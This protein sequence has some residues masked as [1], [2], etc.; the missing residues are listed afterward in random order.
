MFLSSDRS[1]KCLIIYTFRKKSETFYLVL[2]CMTV[3]LYSLCLLQ[4]FYSDRLQPSVLA[5]CLAN[6]YKTGAQTYSSLNQSGPFS[7]LWSWKCFADFFLM[8]QLY[9]FLSNA[10]YPLKSYLSLSFLDKPFMIQPVNALLHRACHYLF[11]HSNVYKQNK[12]LIVLIIH[13]L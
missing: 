3:S 5:Y 9:F 2:S 7:I 8:I 6:I 4:S 10:I 13:Y 1:K 12:M 11:L